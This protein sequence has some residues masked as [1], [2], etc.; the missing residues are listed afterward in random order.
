MLRPGGQR[1]LQWHPNGDEWKYYIKC[2]AQVGV[3]SAG[4]NFRSPSRIALAAPR[5][6]NKSGAAFR[7]A[8]TQYL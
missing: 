7:D 4:P 2:K 6:Q 3:F 1:E 8:T 5:T